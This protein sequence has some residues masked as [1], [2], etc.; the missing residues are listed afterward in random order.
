MDFYAIATINTFKEIYYRKLEHQ[1]EFLLTFLV[2]HFK[3]KILPVL[4]L[5]KGTVMIINNGITRHIRTTGN[6]V[7][8]F[9]PNEPKKYIFYN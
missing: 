5:N 4:M 6:T 9:I 7:F 2:K 8:N 3:L 1:L